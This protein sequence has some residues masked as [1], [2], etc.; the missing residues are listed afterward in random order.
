MERRIGF[1]EFS[2]LC[3]SDA[4]Q[5]N[6]HGEEY[7]AQHIGRFYETFRACSGLIPRG[8]KLLS[9]GAGGAYVET[10][11]KRFYGAEITVADYP[12]AVEALQGDYSRHGFATLGI[13][14]TADR[15]LPLPE[16][17]DAALSLEVIEHLPIPP[18]C[19]LRALYDVLKP[20]GCLVLTT[21]NGAHLPNV[22]RLLR[23]KPILP[24]AELAFSPASYDN[25]HVHRR[26]YVAGEI[27][28][29]MTRAGFAHERTHYLTGRRRTGFGLGRQLR[30]LYG[31][32]PHLKKIM[33]LVGRKTKTEDGGVR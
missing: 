4:R 1:K 11:L 17:F 20:G 10:Q 3:A 23:G 30:R 15:G 33:L 2:S 22:V 32:V 26:E 28:D 24:D 29:A 25:E 7:L 6:R 14:L 8:A 21:P 9:V 31:L 19:H 12:E 16:T 18:R 13:D 5:M 27:I